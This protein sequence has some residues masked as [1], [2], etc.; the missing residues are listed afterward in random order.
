[1]VSIYGLYLLPLLVLFVVWYNV[2]YENLENRGSM[3]FNAT[4]NNISVTSIL[5]RSVLLVEETGIPRENHRTATIHWQTFPHNGVSSTPRLREIRKL[6]F[7][8]FKSIHCILSS[9]R[10]EGHVVELWWSITWFFSVFCFCIFISLCC[11]FD[12][13]S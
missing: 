5:W 11:N 9:Y 8:D 6:V 4:S 2:L 13:N 12:F 3:V 1:M 10:I 7:N